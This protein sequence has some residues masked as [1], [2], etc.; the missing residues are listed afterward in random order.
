MSFIFNGGV[1]D[2]AELAVFETRKSQAR[3]SI[4]MVLLDA[5]VEKNTEEEYNE[6]EY[7][8]DFIHESD[9]SIRVVD[10]TIEKDGFLFELD[11]SVPKIGEFI[12]E[13]TDPI[14]DDIKVIEKTT[15]S[16]TVE[17]VSR[18]DDEATYT[19]WIK[20]NSDGEDAWKEVYSGQDKTCKFE[21]LEDNVLYDI[22]VKIENFRGETER[23]IHTQ[24]NEMPSGTI[25]FSDL[26]WD[27]GNASIVVTTTEDDF[28]LQYQVN[29]TEDDGWTDIENGGT[30]EN[31]EFEDE[32]YARLWDGN[33]GSEHSY[34]KIEDNEPPK[35]F[36]ISASNVSAT[37]FTIN[38]STVDEQSGMNRYEYYV[39]GENK[40]TNNVITGLATGTYSVYVIAY[41]NAGN[42]RQSN[43]IS[44]TTNIA[45]NTPAVTYTGKTTSS[46]SVS[47]TA[48]DENDG[49]NITYTLYTSTSQNG[50]YTSAAS[51][52]VAEGTTVNLT[53]SGLSEYTTYYYYVDVSDG[54]ANTPSST[55]N[56]RTYCSGRTY[57]CRPTRCSGGGS[58]RCSRCGGSGRVKCTGTPTVYRSDRV[59][60][61]CGNTN[62]AHTYYRCP[63]C[64]TTGDGGI[65]CSA[66]GRYDPG[67]N[68]H[69]SATID[70]SSCSGGYVTYTCSHGRTSSHYY[71]SHYTSTSSST[72][73]YCAHNMS[74][75]QHD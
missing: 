70:C 41:D 49:Q 67:T 5:V 25:E 63:R 10:D 35:E 27:G 42:S 69:A 9:D 15:N 30:I 65:N 17:V 47:A 55:S 4:E 66:C 7:L 21:D 64:G 59:T 43:T 28:T 20:K 73:Y 68:N 52:T 1:L 31:L 53:A 44:V 24:T 60:C 26:K 74:G 13:I 29:G 3:E 40:G 62:A 56:V 34:I 6:N 46:I 57:S 36:E 11:R 48:T 51:Q 16:V 45:P 8:D 19:Y 14:I 71:C 72:H 32:V 18:D 61:S 2:K 23:I 37:G 39:E 12:R 38:A 58:R 22:K 33:N 75:V 54:V 50:S